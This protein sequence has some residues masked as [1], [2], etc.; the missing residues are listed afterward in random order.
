MNSSPIVSAILI[1]LNGERFI[2]E[3]IGSVLGQT[4]T[5]WELLLV[6]DGSTDGTTAISKRF[7]AEHPGK[8]FYLE[9]PGHEN[10]GM[11]AAR[12]L[13]VRQAR[14]KF[15]AFI[16]ADDVW[17]PQKLDEQLAILEAH[18]EAAMLYGRSLVWY[19]WDGPQ[20][21]ERDYFLDLG[22]QPDNLIQPPQ[23]LG[24]ML[25]NNRQKPVPSNAV[26][27]R[28]VFD[29]IGMYVEQFR[30]MYEDQVFYTKLM[31][32]FPIYVSDRHW[33]NYRQRD[34]SCVAE[35]ERGSYYEARRPFLG[36]VKQ[37]LEENR[38]RDGRVWRV[39]KWELWK[40][41]HPRI[42]LGLYRLRRQA[43]RLRFPG[44]TARNG[45]AAQARNQ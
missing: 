10:R 41:R 14:G 16:D 4:F 40:S 33:V 15:I 6:D 22:V 31:L 9:H 32:R 37:Y 26:I 2:E 27:R 29:E 17:L 23:L 35:S 36:W 28:E 8:V 1:V 39:L 20:E 18:P 44:K 12:N 45:G 42:A 43:E 34:D 5:D 21:S 11:S 19:S 13:G 24:D 3:A 30:G 7:V 25:T 38:W